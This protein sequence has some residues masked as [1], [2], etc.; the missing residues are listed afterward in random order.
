VARPTA[1]DRCCYLPREVFF[2]RLGFAGAFFTVWASDFGRFLVATSDSFPVDVLPSPPYRGSSAVCCGST[3]PARSAVVH[4]I[5]WRRPRL[6]HPER[7]AGRPSLA[8]DRRGGGVGP[9][10]RH[11]PST[12]PCW[13]P[14]RR[15]SRE[16]RIRASTCRSETRRGH[17]GFE[18][19]EPNQIRR[20]RGSAM[21]APASAVRVRILSPSTLADAASVPMAGSAICRTRRTRVPRPTGVGDTAGAKRLWLSQINPTATRLGG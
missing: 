6:S 4:A 11:W 9:G 12:P 2:G 15:N 5:R 17:G 1:R 7:R 3:S 13:K 14:F 18:K 10:L 8:P 16:R 21:A 20:C 19:P